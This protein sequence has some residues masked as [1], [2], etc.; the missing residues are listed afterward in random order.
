MI[1][2]YAA[3][4]GASGSNFIWSASHGGVNTAQTKSKNFGAGHV[5]TAGWVSLLG[6]RMERFKSSWFHHLKTRTAIH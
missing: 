1:W 4:V 5:I 6:C 3:L 2:A